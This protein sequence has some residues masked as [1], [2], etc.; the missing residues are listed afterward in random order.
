MLTV[1][2][3]V[4]TTNANVVRPMQRTENNRFISGS[5]EGVPGMQATPPWGL[6]THR[7]GFA[8]DVSKSNHFHIL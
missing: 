5:K 7:P 1:P 6:A 4:R 2:V 8:T 3:Q